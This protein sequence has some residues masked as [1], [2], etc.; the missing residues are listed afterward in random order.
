MP[1]ELRP[2]PIPTLRPEGDYLQNAWRKNVYPT[3]ERFGVKI[4]LPRV[5]PQPYTHLAFE[6]FQFAKEQ[7]KANAYNHRI[8]QAFFQEEKDIGKI[9]VLTELAI[10]VGLNGDEFRKALET[11]KY[12]EAHQKALQ[13]A[14]EEA[15]ITAV[16]T[17]IIGDRVL[18]GLYSQETLEQV[19][20][21]EIEKQK[22]T[23]VEGMVCGIDGCD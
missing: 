21:G 9:D 14:Y 16:P 4:V 20:D 12:K 17:F 3:A 1:F 6:G 5:S 10:E 18:P 13:H 2:Y 19:I 11:R 15:K 7:G 8:M 23:F 22:K